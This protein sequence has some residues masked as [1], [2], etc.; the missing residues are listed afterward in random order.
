M[1]TPRIET[2]LQFASMRQI[3][4][5]IEHLE[6]G[7]FE[8]AIALADEAEGTLAGADEVHFLQI[9]KGISRFH[10]VGAAAE[11]TD[12]LNDRMHW[13]K[14]A[15][16]ILHGPRIEKA[17]ITNVEVTATIR[18]AIARFRAVYAEVKTPQMLSFENGAGSGSATGNE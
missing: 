14:H 7:D 3:H 8:C 11:R 6:R 2:N 10:E 4:A 13:L 15:R 16:L 1:G 18:K 12:G 5:A 17:I 9:L